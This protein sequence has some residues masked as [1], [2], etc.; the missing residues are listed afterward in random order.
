MKQECE[1]VCEVGDVFDL[2]GEIWEVKRVDRGVVM[3]GV[4]G[5]D[6]GED[7]WEVGET[8]DISKLI[9]M[10]EDSAEKE[11][12]VE[13]SPDPDVR[14]VRNVWTKGNV[15][16]RVKNVKFMWGIFA[17]NERDSAK[18]DVCNGI[19]SP[20]HAIGGVPG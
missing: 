19:E 2:D 11:D 6:D 13:Y 3:Y 12:E 17:C 14:L 9:G 4:F 7:D 18:C 8:E 20:W 16:E 15:T 1:Y 10:S 5:E